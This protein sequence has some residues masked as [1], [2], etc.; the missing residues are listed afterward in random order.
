M[1][2]KIMMA[3]TLLTTISVLAVFLA[4]LDV[5]LLLVYVGSFTSV[6]LCFVLFILFRTRSFLEAFRFGVSLI[7]HIW[8]SA[9]L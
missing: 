5:R 9:I 2:L 6:D 3:A 8:R 1:D 4:F 7:P